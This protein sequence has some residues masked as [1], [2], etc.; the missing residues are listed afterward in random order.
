MSQIGVNLDKLREKLDKVQR[1]NTTQKSEKSVWFFPEDQS[2]V[3]GANIVRF[4]PWADQPDMPIKELAFYYGIRM[5]EA[6]GRKSKAFLSLRQFGE[7]DPIQEA[8]DVLWKADGKTEDESKQ[9]RELCKKLFPTTVYYFLVLVRGKESEGPKIW[10]TQSKKIY[11]KIVKSILN[12]KKWGNV[13][14]L[15]EGRD[16]EITFDADKERDKTDIDFAIQSSPAWENEEQLKEWLDEKN[17][18]DPLKLLSKRRKTYAELKD[19]FDKWMDSSSS[20][21]ESVGKSGS[22]IEDD[23]DDE[24]TVTSSKQKTEEVTTETKKK[25]SIKEAFQDLESDD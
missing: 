19:V 24:E 1:K 16:M 21:I 25:K 17:M 13:L 2:K 11:E 14:D 6:G 23:D 5:P 7:A 8:I 12:T 4:L 9:D 22:V 10:Q 18:P 15:Q 3:D 20:Q